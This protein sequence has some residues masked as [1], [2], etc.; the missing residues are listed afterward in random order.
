[1]IKKNKK[2]RYTLREVGIQYTPDKGYL[3]VMQELW[4]IKKDIARETKGLTMR[5]YCTYIDKN[6]A[7][8]RERF[9]KK[10]VNLT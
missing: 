8:L 2:Q 6:V 5:E 3:K 9:K 1:M 10:Y 7:H 4:D